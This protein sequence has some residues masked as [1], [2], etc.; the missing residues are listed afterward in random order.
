[1]PPLFFEPLLKRIR[2]GGTRLG[3]VLGKPIGDGDDWAESWEIADH[4]EDQSVVDGGPFDGWTLARLVAE[5]NEELFGAAAGREQF[6]LLI[7][8]LDASDRLS[9]QVH[10]D[11]ALAK[12]YDPVENGKTEA[13]VIL[14]AEPGSLLY[15]GLKADVDEPAMRSALEA[16]RVDECLH[17]LPVAAGDCVFVPAGTVHAIGEGILLA[18]VQQSSDLTF[19]LYDWGRVGAD[20]RPRAIHVEDSIRCTDFAR[21]PVEPVT[22]TRVQGDSGDGDVV[23]QLVECA[24][25]GIRRHVVTKTA[26]FEPS[27]RFRILMTVAGAGVLRWESE[28]RDVP[29]GT[30]VL[31][32]AAAPQVTFESQGPSTLL[33]ADVPS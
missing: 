17:T 11:D 3:S 20:G 9:V 26:E 2:W 10:P 8:F 15:A 29:L 14:D 30:S 27:D 16:G 18:E 19:R 24:Y 28:S 22:P 4:G 1:M 13:W 21:G 23:E 33:E 5:K 32:P 6:P 12:R 25:F 31:L 7:K